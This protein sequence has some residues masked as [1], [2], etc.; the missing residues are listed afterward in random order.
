MYEL[1]T[2]PTNKECARDCRILSAQLDRQRTGGEAVNGGKSAESAATV[3]LETVMGANTNYA[4][5]F[6]QIMSEQ[7]MPGAEILCKT[8]CETTA[9]SFIGKLVGR[10]PEITKGS[11]IYGYAIGTLKI[12]GEAAWRG[13]LYLGGDGHLWT[14]EDATS[15]GLT[16]RAKIVTKLDHTTVHFGQ[17]HE[18]DN[19]IESWSRYHVK[20]ESAFR[21]MHVKDVLYEIARANLA[22]TV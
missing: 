5:E 12:T 22:P 6:I 4:L 13:T 15:E 2:A 7:G 21:E 14:H 1:Q 11:A 17:V 3:A 9:P 18:R 16:D 10:N 8:S 19:P 20:D